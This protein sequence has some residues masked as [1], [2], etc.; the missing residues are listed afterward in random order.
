[1]HRLFRGTGIPSDSIP[2]A[3]FSFE[4]KLGE[5]EEVA[6]ALHR[7]ST[8]LRKVVVLRFYSD[9]SYAEIAQTLNIP[10]GT[11]QSRLNSAILNMRSYLKEP[12]TKSITAIDRTP[13]VGD[14]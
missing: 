9:M 4:D 13:R 1:M 5:D 7:L 6:W 11:V 8:K 3:D 2:A 14:E 10:I 12:L